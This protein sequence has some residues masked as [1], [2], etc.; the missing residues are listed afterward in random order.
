MLSVCWYRNY[1]CWRSCCKPSQ[2]LHLLCEVSSWADFTGRGFT[3]TQDPF[4]CVSRGVG[5]NQRKSLEAHQTKHTELGREQGG[6]LV[7]MKK[8]FLAYSGTQS[9]VLHW[10]WA[11][12]SQAPPDASASSQLQ[13]VLAYSTKINVNL[14]KL[15]GFFCIRG[16]EE[17]FSSYPWIWPLLMP[18]PSAPL[19]CEAGD[20][21]AL[22]ENYYF[23]HY[24]SERSSEPGGITGGNEKQRLV[25]LQY[26]LWPLQ[27]HIYIYILYIYICV[28]VCMQVP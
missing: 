13:F 28:Y 12:P 5:N 17:K 3:G 6:H 1:R 9:Q 4:K 20:H 19:M 15:L 7:P 25:F 24:S 18:I 11:L 23:I 27:I 22:R 2:D 14:R 10:C 26:R 8:L 16:R 21:T